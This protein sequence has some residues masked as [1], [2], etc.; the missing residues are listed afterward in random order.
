VS[1]PG[2]YKPNPR[3]L[4]VRELIRFR[5]LLR[6]PLAFFTTRTKSKPGD[7]VWMPS[8]WADIACTRQELTERFWQIT[9]PQRHAFEKLGFQEC[10]LA[11]AKPHLNLNPHIQDNGKITYLDS[12]RSHIG[13]IVYIKIHVAP[14]IDRDRERVNIGITA[15]FA[16]GTVTY[17]NNNKHTDPVP[18]HEVFTVGSDDPGVIYA[19]FL[20]HLVRRKEPPQVFPD[21]G[22]LHRWVDD[23]QMK[24]FERL[25]QR[26]LFIRMTDE[27]VAEARRKLPPPLKPWA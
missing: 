16:G 15:V 23:E 26:G 9:E 4:S 2:F 11:K 19:R 17:R 7:G 21:D 25:V 18:A 24:R 14:P 6:F 22:S 5:G 20:P 27:E 1:P 8:L 3:V 10:G 13:Q 12:S